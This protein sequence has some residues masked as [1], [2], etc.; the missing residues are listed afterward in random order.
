MQGL[1]LR[2]P[3]VLGEIQAGLYLLHS[4]HHPVASSDSLQIAQKTLDSQF[5][6]NK[7]SAKSH[8]LHSVSNSIISMSN[9]TYSCSDLWNIRLGHLPQSRMKYIPGCMQHNSSMNDFPCTICPLARQ[10]KLPFPISTSFTSH[11]FELI[12]IDTW[13][14]YKA[15]LM[16]ALSTSSL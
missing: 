2:R 8:T 11:I 6:S 1:S 9:C 10:H 7:V 14:T 5:F 15:I 3:L 12:H 13:G 4:T 16:M